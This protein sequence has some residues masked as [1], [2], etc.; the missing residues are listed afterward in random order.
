MNRRRRGK[1][2]IIIRVRKLVEQGMPTFIGPAANGFPLAVLPGEDQL[3]VGTV[4]AVISVE[5]EFGVGVFIGPVHDARADALGDVL[6][7]FIVRVE[8]GVENDASGSING[9]ITGGKLF[10]VFADGDERFCEAPDYETAC[11]LLDI[12]SGLLSAAV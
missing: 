2:R 5:I 9:L 11:S 4:Q 7:F 8:T 3:A 10:I 12:L 6:V 1:Q